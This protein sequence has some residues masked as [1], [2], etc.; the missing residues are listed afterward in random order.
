MH[1]DRIRL[2]AGTDYLHKIFNL[3]IPD[4][5]SYMDEKLIKEL[6]DKMPP[7]LTIKKV[8]KAMTSN[9]QNPL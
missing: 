7:V 5:Y 2:Y 4:I 6:I 9:K 1:I 3:E 8:E